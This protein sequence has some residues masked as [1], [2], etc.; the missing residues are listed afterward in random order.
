[1]G[2]MIDA[3]S[4]FRVPSSEFQPSGNW[5]WSPSPLSL[6]YYTSMTF[7]LFIKPK[8]K[9]TISDQSL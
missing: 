5:F 7:T 9:K 8:K 4:E 6:F 3:S 2:F 1:M